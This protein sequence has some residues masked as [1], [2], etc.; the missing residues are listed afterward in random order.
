MQ[1]PIRRYVAT[2]CASGMQ[3]NPYD[4]DSDDDSDNKDINN[5][6]NRLMMS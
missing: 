6:L 4:D 1:M 3:Q 2:D 5:D